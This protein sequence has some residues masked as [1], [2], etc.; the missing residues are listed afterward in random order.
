MSDSN[1][2]EVLVARTT[3]DGQSASNSANS[4]CL[5]SSFSCTASC[6]MKAPFTAS[7]SEGSV[8]TRA[9]IAS[10]A[11]ESSAKVAAIGRARSAKLASNSVFM[12]HSATSWPWW[13]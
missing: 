12:S 11:A 6:T 4:A 8:R 10:T 9:S 13:A 7:A 1:S 2:D 5:V 3:S